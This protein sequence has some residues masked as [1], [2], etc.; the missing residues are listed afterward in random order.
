M[1]NE[2]TKLQN[3]LTEIGLSEKEAGVY[4]SLLEGLIGDHSN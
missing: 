4:I 3:K 1:K 2:Q